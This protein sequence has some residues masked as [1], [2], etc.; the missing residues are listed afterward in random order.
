MLLAGGGASSLLQPAATFS[1]AQIILLSANGTGVRDLQIA[2]A[3]TTYSANPAANGIQVTGATN[4][5]INTV[6]LL[7][8][9]GWALQATS[10]A[11][12]NNKYAKLDGIYTS[13]CAQGI[14]VGGI[15]ANNIASHEI[16]NC[17]MDQVQNG[18][19]YFIEHATDI[20]CSNLH[21]L[22]AAGSG[23]ALHIKDRTSSIHV[24]NMV[25]SGTTPTSTGSAL[26]IETGT[27]GT[28]AQVDLA[29]SIFENANNGV[30][31]SAGTEISMS[32]CRFENNANNGVNITGGDTISISGCSFNGNGQTAGASRYD[33]Q[34]STANNVLVTHS[35]FLTP[36]GALAGQVNNAVNVTAG[37]VKMANDIFLNTPVFNNVPSEVRACT[38][39]NPV[40]QVTAPTF[41]ASTVAATNNTGVDVT[42]FITNGTGAITQVQ[43]AGVGGN[44]VNTNFQIAASGWGAFRIPAG[45]S[46]KFTY[47]SGSPAWTWMGE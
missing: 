2:Y 15:T 23:A 43:V 33:F 24:A 10:T 22:V 25:A 42:A 46:V 14:H 39:Y 17:R 3:N 18:D 11:G 27:D 41:P 37:K 36:T 29:N 32:S 20:K 12:V 47:G 21:G 19:A 40:G 31:I 9:N 28:P 34:S 6:N 45:G 5:L 4:V 13:L 26:L 7:Y 38:G 44:Y 35:S 30:T 16:T 1:G 8:I